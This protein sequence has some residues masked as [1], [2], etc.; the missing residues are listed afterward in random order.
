LDR[1]ARGAL[2]GDT[3]LITTP[4]FSRHARQPK[5][6]AIARMHPIQRPQRQP[7]APGYD[8]ARRALR[9]SGRWSVLFGAASV[10]IGI[11][12]RPVDWVITVLG[13]ALIGSGAWNIAAPRPATVV[14]DGIT[15]LL[16]GGYYLMGA[17]LT[18]MDGVPFPPGRAILGLVQLLWGIR[19]FR[20]L[21]HFG[22]AI[23]SF[24]GEKQ[25]IQVL[26]GAIKKVA[27]SDVTRLLEFEAGEARG[28]VWK[29]R[30]EG[31]RIV[32]QEVRGPGIVIGTRA[33]TQI[34]VRPAKDPKAPREA[35]ISV[36]ATCIRVR[37]SLDALRALADWKAGRSTRKA[38]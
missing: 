32:F 17:V 35:E 14:A 36:G 3:G 21:G 19:R 18:V 10:A 15:L 1:E 5:T 26:A 33:T 13:A 34:M 12:F 16:V 30:I 6:L 2:K 31:D 22:N 11:L 23:P 37:T 27:T 24:A 4:I 25:A 8:T 28:R 20:H 7:T 9:R 29:A 38:A